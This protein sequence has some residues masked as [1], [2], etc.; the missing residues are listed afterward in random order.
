MK[1]FLLLAFLVTWI[2]QCLWAAD[3]TAVVIE[4]N[5]NLA[6]SGDK[7]HVY[8][9]STVTDAPTGAAWP[10]AAMETAVGSDGNTYKV[11]K[12]PAGTDRVIF[13]SGWDTAQTADL[14]Y[15]GAVVMNDEGATEVAVVFEGVEPDPEPVVIKGDYNLAYSGDK[16][17]VYY[18]GEGV[19]SPEWPGVA[20]ETAVGSDG[21]TYKV[22]KVPAGTTNVIFSIT[23]DDDKTGD[24]VYT[25]S[26]VMSDNGATSVAVTF[27]GVEPE[28]EPVVIDGDYNLAYSGDKEKVYYYGEGVTSPEWPGVAMETAVGSDGN[29]YKVAKVP[30]GTLN[31]IFSITGDDDKTGDLAYTGSYIMNDNGAT[32]TKVVFNNGTVGVEN[33]ATEKVDAIKVYSAGGQLYI[34][35]TEAAVVKVTNLSGITTTLDVNAGTNCFGGFARGLYLVNGKKVML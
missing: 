5:Y 9:Y 26:F 33:I 31:V 32:A 27:E 13:N 29:T 28:P 19:T 15:T 22:F 6:Y 25:G 12:V 30:A 23:G 1:K 3:P 34:V 8:C 17:K 11:F 4:G 10:G 20:M 21:N 24:L 7:T 16:A 18:Y 14:E 2:S 35:T